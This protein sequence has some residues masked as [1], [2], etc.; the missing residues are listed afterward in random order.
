[1]SE[2]LRFNQG[3]L[4]YDLLPPGPIRELTK[5]LTRGAEKYA[6]RNWENGMKW[7]TVIASLRRHLD[8][9]ENSED[10]DI[11]SGLPHL[12]HAMTNILFLMEY[13]NTHP[14]HD[15][16]EPWFKRPKLRV[17]LDIDGVVADFESHFLKHFGY[18]PK[19]HATDWDDWRFRNG[20][21]KLVNDK[22]FWLSVPKIVSS[23]EF[24]YPITGYCT[25]RSCPDEFTLDWL[26]I[27]GFPKLQYINVKGKSKAEALRGICDVFADDSINNFMDLQQN[28]ILCY[29]LSRHHNVKYDVGYYRVNNFQEFMER[30]KCLKMAAK[31]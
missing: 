28:G 22:D 13:M 5:V 10:F 7:S 6:P 29:L 20:M 14:E 15:D 1:M 27:N 23:N 2:G 12:S 18:D 19:D 21:G 24:T 9:F 25:S 17:W 4:R 16:R 8:S 26:K 30:V 31:N 3:K 11:E